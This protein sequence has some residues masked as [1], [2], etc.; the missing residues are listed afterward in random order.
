MTQHR[1]LIDRF[2][3]RSKTMRPDEFRTIR[4]AMGLTQAE[5]ADLLGYAHAATVAAFETD[6]AAKSTRIIPP[7]L[8]RLMRAY[9][10]GYRPKG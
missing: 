1:N 3:Q 8:V 5:L 6:P 2:N 7:L 4:L 10:A 9:E